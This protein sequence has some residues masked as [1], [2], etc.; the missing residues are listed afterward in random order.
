MSVHGLPGNPLKKS[1]KNDGNMEMFEKQVETFL[2]VQTA[3]NWTNKFRTQPDDKS[4]IVWRYSG[5]EELSE[6]W[7]SLNWLSSLF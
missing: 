3:G 6:I 1:A 4:D 5:L 2:G 7:K